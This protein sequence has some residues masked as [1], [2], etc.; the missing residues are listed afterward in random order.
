[1]TRLE[2]LTA[3]IASLNNEI[4]ALKAFDFDALVAATAT[5]ERSL[6][7]LHGVQR[8]EMTPE[9]KALAEEAA[10]L[11]ETARTYVNLMAANVRRQLDQITGQG[12]VAYAKPTLR[13]A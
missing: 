5:K 10:R 4:A 3:V 8:D 9:V 11:N 12:P 13:V 6:G 7:N 2:A 1:M